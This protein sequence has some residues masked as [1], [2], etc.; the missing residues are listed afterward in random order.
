MTQSI[1]WP[2][3]STRAVPLDVRLHAPVPDVVVVR[4]AG[5][6]DGPSA[7]LL[8]ERVGQQ[9]CRARHIVVDLGGVTFLGA[10][11]LRTLRALFGRASAAGVRLHLAADHRTVC[12]PLRLAGLDQ[13]MVLSPSAD[14]VLARLLCRRGAG[15]GARPP[16]AQPRPR[17]STQ[18]ETVIAEAMSGHAD[19][20]V[21]HAVR[22]ARRVPVPLGA[23][24]GR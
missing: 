8:A 14:L 21:G 7:P 17:T 20:L 4:I 1:E 11:G 13:L 2:A 24:R 5:A 18:L 6:L 12:R 16:A 23:P 3:G 15:S 19:R 10:C 9:F 22:A